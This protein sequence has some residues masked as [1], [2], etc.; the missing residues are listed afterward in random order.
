[1]PPTFIAAEIEALSITCLGSWMVHIMFNATQGIQPRLST[2]ALSNSDSARGGFGISRSGTLSRP[3]QDAYASYQKDTTVKSPATISTRADYEQSSQ[4]SASARLDYSLLRGIRIAF[5]ARFWHY[6]RLLLL[7]AHAPRPGICTFSTSILY[8]HI[9][10]C[11]TR[12]SETIA[13]KANRLIH[14]MIECPLE[15]G[16][17]RIR[18]QCVSLGL[19]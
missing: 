10:Q 2:T 1:M 19:R 6:A 8:K 14:A 5:V 4:L 13:L 18:W 16:K 3:R 12:W 17:K 7:Q 15:E 9:H 11:C